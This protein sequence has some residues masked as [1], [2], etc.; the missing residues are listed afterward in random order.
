MDGGVG[1]VDGATE[2]FAGHVPPVEPGAAL[3]CH[4]FQEALPPPVRD[5]WPWRSARAFGSA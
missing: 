3:G 4:G 5:G 2:S 1:T